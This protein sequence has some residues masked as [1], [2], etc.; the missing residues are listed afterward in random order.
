MKNSS[1]IRFARR[2][3]GVFGNVLTQEVANQRLANITRLDNTFNDL[4]WVTGFDKSGTTWMMSL[5][6]DIPGLVCRG[7]GQFFNYCRPD[8]HYLNNAG[9]F[10]S[11]VESI[12]SLKWYS[13]SGH[14]WFDERILPQL[15]RSNIGVAMKAFGGSNAKLI[16]DKST[17]Q[18][19]KMIQNY[20]KDAR[21][22]VMVRDPKDVCVSF[23]YHFKLRGKDKLIDGRISTDFAK[24]VAM[25]WHE[26]YKHCLE[27]KSNAKFIL[28]ND[29]LN[30][31]SQKMEE[32]VSFLGHSVSE[33]D[34]NNS[35]KK[36]DF[37]E[38]TGR[39][40]GVQAESFFRKGIV[41]DWV[42]HLSQEQADIINEICRNEMNLLGIPE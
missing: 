3:I 20:F 11:I 15:V 16:G 21:I 22:I 6:N 27:H 4:F 26:Y 17:C 36:N 23:A 9:G 41:G 7:S 33:V 13:G 19:L 8:I 39:E 40:R 25:A 38:L 14:T 12:K 24:S 42:N 37:K 1:V 32:I 34:I 30:K 35:V 29:L 28:Y 2:V 10:N 5:L 18:D 31:C